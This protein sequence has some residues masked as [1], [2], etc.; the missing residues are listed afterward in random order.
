MNICHDH[1]R[2]VTLLN[3]CKRKIAIIYFIFFMPDFGN[4][5]IRHKK[6][7]SYNENDKSQ[8]QRDFDKLISFDTEM[9]NHSLLG[10]PQLQLEGQNC[11]GSECLYCNLV[12][13]KM[14]KMIDK[15][16]LCKFFQ[17]NKN[18]KKSCQTIFYFY[19]IFQFKMSAGP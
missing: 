11:R 2:G 12:C 3:V 13:T 8:K 19:F 16:L 17:E 1:L 7:K 6:I 4:V 10:E 14:M 9:W 5:R 18:T 15:A